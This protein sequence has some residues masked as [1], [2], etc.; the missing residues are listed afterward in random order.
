M[1]I[2]NIDFKCI[3]AI[4]FGIRQYSVLLELRAKLKKNKEYKNEMFSKKELFNKKQKLILE[5]FD[6]P[7]IVFFQII[8]LVM[9]H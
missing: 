8:K 7:S 6:L 9:L 4:K 2:L 3:D 1:V 5:I